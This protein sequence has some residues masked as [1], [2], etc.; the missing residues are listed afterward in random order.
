M[1]NE[2]NKEFEALF[3]VYHLSKNNNKPNNKKYVCKNIYEP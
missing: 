1:L 3:M 2:N